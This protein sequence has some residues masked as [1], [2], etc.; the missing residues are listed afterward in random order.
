MTKEKMFPKKPKVIGLEY[1]AP[2]QRL[3]DRSKE[4][5]AIDSGFVFLSPG[6]SVGE[7]STENFEEVVVFLE[8]EGKAVIES[9][10]LAVSRGRVLYVPPETK[11]DI[12]NTGS[13]PLRYVYIVTKAWEE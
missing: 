10:G 13:E 1:S 3:L 9:E 6:E 11:H 4:T 12:V 7:H 2:Y 8:G 5:S